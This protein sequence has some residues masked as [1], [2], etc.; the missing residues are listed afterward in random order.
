MK[1][2]VLFSQNEDSGQARIYVLD[3]TREILTYKISGNMRMGRSVA[4]AQ[5]EIPLF[6]SIASRKHGEFFQLDGKFY[7]KDTR[8]ANGT[9]INGEKIGADQ[10]TDTVLLKDG[11]VIRID[12]KDLL[13]PHADAVVIVFAYGEDTQ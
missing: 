4:E 3:K 11:D 6:S 5:V 2:T 10:E 1:E 7:Y 13:H 8:S 12:H 9:F